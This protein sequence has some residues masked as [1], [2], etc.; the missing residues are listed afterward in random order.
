M[1]EIIT[2]KVKINKIGSIFYVIGFLFMLIS[3]IV[4]MFKTG[5]ED[6]MQVVAWVLLGVSGYFLYSKFDTL[7]YSKIRKNPKKIKKVNKKEVSKLARYFIFLLLASHIINIVTFFYLLGTGLP[8]LAI[9]LLYF[10]I[11]FG[12]AT[13]IIVYGILILLWKNGFELKKIIE[14]LKKKERGGSTKCKEDLK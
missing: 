2:E 3:G 6:R 11:A 14:R 9:L 8:N 10:P 7:V 5:S 4:L 1:K 12:W 13:I